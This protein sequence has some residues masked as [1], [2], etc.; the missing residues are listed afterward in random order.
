MMM[1]TMSAMVLN[2]QAMVLDKGS[3]GNSVYFDENATLAEDSYHTLDAARHILINIFKFQQDDLCE[4]DSPIT[5]KALS[6]LVAHPSLAYEEFEASEDLSF[7]FLPLSI[8]IASGAP[9]GVIAVIH[10]L[11]PDA[12]CS[13]HPI[14][15]IYVSVFLWLFALVFGI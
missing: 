5:H 14:L 12:A 6:L 10:K 11:N 9:L 15:K 8:F 2:M 13:R 4:D 3:T 7:R 1:T